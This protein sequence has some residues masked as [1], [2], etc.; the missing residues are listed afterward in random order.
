M[1]NFRNPYIMNFC[2]M[3]LKKKDPEL[4]PD[5]QAQKVDTM[6]CDFENMLGKNMVDALPE[7]NRSEYLAQQKSTEVD[8]EKIGKMFEEN[9]SN[10]DE[11]LKKTMEEFA[12]LFSSK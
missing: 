6:Y 2:Q 5:E 12:A 11:I 3:L 1:E 4:S 9:I 10:P 7:D 8:F